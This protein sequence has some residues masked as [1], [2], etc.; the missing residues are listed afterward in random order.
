MTGVDASG[1]LQPRHASGLKLLD[2]ADLVLDNGAPAGDALLPSR[3]GRNVCAAS[4]ITT[5]L[6]SQ[7][8][9]AEV[10]GLF[11]DAG[12]EPPVYVSANVPDGHETD[13]EAESAYRHRLRR[14]G[15]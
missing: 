10:A 11:V 15:F 5:A 14:I 3:S 2:V 6:L 7:M 12:D 13:V 4:S 8:L 9:V 1:A